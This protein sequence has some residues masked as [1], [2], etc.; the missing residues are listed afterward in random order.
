MLQKLGISMESNE[1]D[2][3]GKAL[4]YHVMQNW[5]PAST[6]LLEMMIFHLPSPGRDRGIMWKT[7][8]RV[9]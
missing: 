1:K 3:T 6:V 8:T 7:C 5:L 4:M 2:L 9:P